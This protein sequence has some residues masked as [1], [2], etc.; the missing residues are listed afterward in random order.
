MLRPAQAIIAN[1]LPIGTILCGT[2]FKANRAKI[3]AG[4]LR[5]RAADPDPYSGNISGRS[6][7]KSLREV[8]GRFRPCM[9]CPS[10]MRTIRRSRESSIRF[11]QRESK[12]VKELYD[13]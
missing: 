6:L 5:N 1:A 7:S 9:N 13:K 11:L 4:K 10:E 12:S 8:R 3:S 2:Q